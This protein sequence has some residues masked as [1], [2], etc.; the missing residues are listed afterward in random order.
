MI[1]NRL[2]GYLKDTLGINA[3][4]APFSKEQL[5]VLP[6]YVSESYRFYDADLFGRPLILVEPV[7]SSEIDPQR[8]EKV[9]EL[10]KATFNKNSALLLDE[11][12][13]YARKRLINRGIG[14][15]VPGK[16]LFLPQW[17]IDLRE[18]A[19]YKPVVRR[20]ESLLPSAQFLVIYHILD[21]SK[22]GKLEGQSLKKIAAKFGYTPMGI[23]K[24]VENLQ[25]F[26]L[27][28]VAK[29]K[30]KCIHFRLQRQE[31]WRTLEKENLFINPVLKRVYVDERP[32]KI[33]M[34][35]SNA[36]ALPAYTDMNPVNVE[37]Y[38]IGRRQ[39][40][41]MREKKLLMNANEQNGPYCL[42][43]WKYDPLPLVERLA[44]DQQVVD[45]LSLYL[46]LKDMQDE[47]IQLALEQ[48]TNKYIW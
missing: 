20:Q 7:E 43:V 39:F 17:M 16:Q 35:E 19:Q 46:S 15:I 10:L 26:D 27:V 9:V 6:L 5:K 4:A 42:E 32:K 28:D 30:E 45:P 22:E 25:H 41:E 38:A 23:T 44:N 40:Y 8:T 3:Q 21:R 37:Y 31:L 36:S 2:D 14:F 24:A 29:G 33:F 34:L 12:P 18:R 48:I 13:A 11:L 1:L 47:R